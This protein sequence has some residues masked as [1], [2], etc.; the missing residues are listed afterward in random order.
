MTE[1]DIRAG[2]VVA[3]RY[4]VGRL[5][6]SGSMGT[7]RAALDLELE[8]EVAIKFV[9]VGTLAREEAVERFQREIDVVQRIRSEHVVR[10]LDV[11]T[12]PDGLPF[13]VM[14]LLVGRGL[15]EE[16]ELRGLIP[17]DEA[18]SL[19]LPAIEVLAEAHAT[20]VVHRDIKPANLFLEERPD[21]PRRVK[22]LDF[23]V[24][25]SNLAGPN[26]FVTEVGTITGSPLY[27][28]PEQLRSSETADA[29]AD[30]WSLGAILFE[31]VTGFTAHDGDSVAE[32]CAALLRDPPRRITDFGTEL[33]D[34]FVKVVMRCLEP[35]R[36]RRYSNVAELGEA[37]LPFS[38]GGVVHVD[39]AREALAR[40][41]LFARDPRDRMPTSDAPVT[42]EIRESGRPP[43]SAAFARPD[44]A[45][46]ADEP[47][48]F[49][50]LRT[51]RIAVAFTFVGLGVGTAFLL[52]FPRDARRD[53]A[54]R[55][56]AALL[57]SLVSAAPVPPNGASP[58][59]GATAPVVTVSPVA[60]APLA[61]PLPAASPTA[62]GV[63]PS[64]EAKRPSSR[65]PPVRKWTPKRKSGV[66]SRPA[67]AVEVTDFGGRR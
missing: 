64:A 52:E 2:R 22:V 17:V 30:I 47:Q 35:D 53:P 56:A 50:K 62:S 36:E 13:M 54:A 65:R 42:A 39:R 7:V 16:R 14:E 3:E 38:S 26:S 25:K 32:V 6:G 49:G 43:R 63:A 37:L 18:V 9:S 66:G 23:G 41:A 55:P 60:A 20:G 10:V 31:L 29:R 11:G 28:A 44:R 27:M 21:A 67:A 59:L 1:A 24:S 15:D 45:A 34:G 46:R 8:R 57:A 5:L 12:L 4:V 33:P 61:P 51:F 48:D 40:S 19:V 58:A